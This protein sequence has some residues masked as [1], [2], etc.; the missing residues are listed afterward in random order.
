M[1]KLHKVLQKQISEQTKGHLNTEIDKKAI[2]TIT[3][4]ETSSRSVIN[5]SIS[6]QWTHGSYNLM[7]TSGISPDV[8]KNYSGSIKWEIVGPKAILNSGVPL[9]DNHLYGVQLYTTKDCSVPFEVSVSNGNVRIYKATENTNEWEFVA[10]VT[11]SKQKVVNVPIASYKWQSVVIIFYSFT[12]NSE[13]YIGVDYSQLISWRNLDILS[14]DTPVWA[15]VPLQRIVVDDEVKKVKLR[16]G[17]VKDTS[18]GFGGNGIYKKSFV[19]TGNM[20]GAVV[21]A[22]LSTRL[23]GY[24]SNA[25]VN[26]WVILF[27]SN[28]ATLNSGDTISNSTGVTLTWTA[29]G[30]DYEAG[31][32]EVYDIR[33]SAT[34][35]TEGNFY[36]ATRILVD[37]TPTIPGNTETVN[38]GLPVGTWYVA[39]KAGD[40]VQ[41]QNI[42]E[43]EFGNITYLTF[44]GRNWSALSNVIQKTAVV[45][46]SVATIAQSFY[47]PANLV[48]NSLFNNSSSNWTIPSWATI[49]NDREAELGRNYLSVNKL[50]S[51]LGTTNFY[52]T[53]SIFAVSTTNIYTFGVAANS[54]AI[55]GGKFNLGEY[56]VT[57]SRWQAVGS[58]TAVATLIGGMKAV[59]VVR[60]K[61]GGKLRTSGNN[62]F[63]TK[64]MVHNV[65]CLASAPSF[66]DY[67]ISFHDSTDATIAETNTLL[68]SGVGFNVNQATLVP[69]VSGWGYANI[70]IFSTTSTIVFATLNFSYFSVGRNYTPS[71]L[72]QGLRVLFYDSG[73]TPCSTTHYDYTIDNE[74]IHTNIA[75]RI[76]SNSTIGT[77]SSTYGRTFP[78]SCSYCKL[79][80]FATLLSA[81]GSF[82]INKRFF[83]FMFTEELVDTYKCIFATESTWFKTVGTQLN[84]LTGN[85][86]YL[87]QYEHVIDRSKNPQDGNISY[88]DDYDIEIDS[89]YSYYIDAYDTSP[90]KNRSSLSVVASIYSGDVTAPATPSSYSLTPAAGGLLHSWVNPTAPDLKTIRCYSD[91]GLT[92]IKW[93]MTTTATGRAMMYSEIVLSTAL[94]S[95][96]ITAIDAYKNESAAILATAIP[97][98]DVPDYPKISVVL[99]NESGDLIS[100]NEYGWFNCSVVASV[101]VDD[102]SAPI[103]SMFAS[104]MLP[105]ISE[106]WTAWATF[107]GQITCL[108]A[109]TYK[110]YLRMKVKDIYNNY[111]D[112]VYTNIKADEVAP[113]I[114][115]GRNFWNHN[116]TDGYETYVSL[117]YN[118]NV[119]SDAV[120]GSS[121][122]GVGFNKIF[123][124]RAEI[125]SLLGNPC[126]ENYVLS[127]DVVKPL[128]WSVEEPAYATVWC[129]ADYKSTDR[130]S[131]GFKVVDGASRREIKTPA[132]ET[133]LENGQEYLV[134][135]NYCAFPSGSSVGTIKLYLDAIP[136]TSL[137]TVSNVVLSTRW[138]QASG[139]FTYDKATANTSLVIGINGT[140]GDY[141]LFDEVMV[142]KAPTFATVSETR[143][144]EGAKYIDSNVKPWVRYLYRAKA[145][146]PAGNYSNYSYYKEV[147]P[148]TTYRNKYRNLIGNSSFE[149]ITYTSSGTLIPAEWDNWTW[150]SQFEK[151]YGSWVEVRQ[152][153]GAYH[154]T[155]YIET[156][157]GWTIAK[158]D[159]HILP[160]VGRTKCYVVSAY[161]YNPGA[162]NRTGYI[163]LRARNSERAEVTTKLISKTAYATMTDWYRLVATLYVAEASVA[164]LGMNIT[165]MGSIR[166]DA[167]QLEESNTPDPTDYYDVDVITADHI[168]GA[169]IRG[170]WIE[171]EQIYGGH[172]RANTITATNIKAGTI[173]ASL[174]KAGTINAT[175]IKAGAINATLIKAGT[176]TA[177]QIAA[178][179]ITASL[180]KAGTINATLIKAGAINAT[181]ISANTIETGN[182]KLNDAYIYVK[183][184]DGNIN[185][186]IA[187]AT[188]GFIDISSSLL[189][190]VEDRVGFAGVSI[191]HSAGNSKFCANMWSLS[192]DNINSYNITSLDAYDDAPKIAT[193]YAYSSN[194]TAC[195]LLTTYGQTTMYSCL[196]TNMS[197]PFPDVTTPQYLSNKMKSSTSKI[198]KSRVDDFFIVCGA[199]YHSPIS[200]GIQVLYLNSKTGT[201]HDS[202]LSG[203]VTGLRPLAVSFDVDTNSQ[204]LV[205]W[206]S[207]P[208]P[209]HINVTVYDQASLSPIRGF[210]IDTFGGFSSSVATMYR[211]DVVSCDVTYI[212]GNEYLLTYR[213]QDDTYTYYKVITSMGTVLNGV[214]RDLVLMPNDI[215]FGGNLGQFKTFSKKLY[216]TSGDVIVFNSPNPEYSTGVTFSDFPLSPRGKFCYVTKISAT[217]PIAELLNLLS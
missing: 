71:S 78:A 123:L 82:H 80:Y 94:A 205:T 110:T 186:N 177:T 84:L 149:K 106:E 85:N 168:Q 27:G 142:V 58:I 153:E 127:G 47:V 174:I 140:T 75:Y 115:P 55:Y 167:V 111:S 50:I 118:N 65:N 129:D 217:L 134:Y 152:G 119:V 122:Y 15:S 141:V 215:G 102:S 212:E 133:I 207:E 66:G 121:T 171:G 203:S 36:D 170:N 114:T 216:E 213:L 214:N 178:E 89:T 192:M 90:F 138:V 25:D 197:S 86:I 98:Q 136:A 100:P 143:T 154:G 180:I 162:A 130:Y 12:S 201:M 166:W 41:P 200:Y 23:L 190:D 198:V 189:E 7:R 33:Y 204:L 62:L 191:Y 173:T 8:F 202:L 17:W 182:L 52:V 5:N 59:S 51:S 144:T 63:F 40:E 199:Y 151:S 77:I 176:I 156:Q 163:Q 159:I 187:V 206:T 179:T 139:T 101:L 10:E 83:K 57:P 37:I 3:Q 79:T 53:S 1:N 61:S 184:K 73:K 194:G 26:T 99:R 172:I 117:K 103:A 60:E 34:L 22:T 48:K 208:T 32:A 109:V 146:D 126:F 97:L 158:N 88:W 91:V 20:V 13:Y 196:S 16:L 96:Y 6:P 43:D 185:N 87:A 9:Y 21:P 150:N 35:I 69:S 161:Y 45:S 28:N 95:R 183:T 42:E 137:I 188:Q 169:L 18:I 193:Q 195:I 76:G 108:A 104:A 39:I 125:Q 160:Y 64:G 147:R 68:I 54:E 157:T 113:I 124:Q 132:N 81:T 93:E 145:Q 211:P 148:V 128:K 120:S 19:D 4:K 72:Q 107:N 105:I 112:V 44:E 11:D 181:L 92:S 155:N 74:S 31:V 131:M 38:V 164:Y 49:K 29:V 175:L 116:D 135:F 46:G 30:D 165:S 67:S 14:P 70:N 209:W 210:Q 24:D 56:G 2:V